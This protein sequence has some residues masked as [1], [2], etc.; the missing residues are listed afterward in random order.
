MLNSLDCKL[1]AAEC[2]KLAEGAPNPPVQATL[3]DMSR[4]WTRLAL[5]AEQTLKQSRPPSGSLPDAS[6]CVGDSRAKAYARAA[7]SL[8]ALVVP[9]AQIVEAG[10]L[11]EIPGIGDAIADIVTKLH[12]TGT[13]PSLEAMRKG[14]S[15]AVLEMLAVPGLRPDKV[16]KLYKTLGITSLADLEQAAR[17]DRIKGAKGLGGALAAEPSEASKWR[18]AARAVFTCTARQFCSKTQYEACTRRIR[19]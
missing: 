4:T 11:T 10:R 5:E 14:I 15:G 18:A 8:S 13:H 3:R 9:L 2:E 7:D 19:S 6:F 17:E 1:R 16:L 12:R